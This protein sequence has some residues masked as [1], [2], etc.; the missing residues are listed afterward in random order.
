MK[1][2]LCKSAPPGF[3]HQGISAASVSSMHTDMGGAGPGQKKEAEA[4][5][6]AKT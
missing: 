4:N 6:E 3:L 1:I 5:T 2:W